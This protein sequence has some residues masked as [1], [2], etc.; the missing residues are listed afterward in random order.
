MSD[1]VSSRIGSFSDV[2]IGLY[3]D[4]PMW[5]DIS[6]RFAEKVSSFYKEE[7]IRDI[8]IPGDI[9]HN[10]SE[11][12]VK[13]IH[14]A[15]SFFDYFKDFNIII[16]AGN[17]D[18][19]FK[20]KAEINSIC[21]FDGWNNITIVDKTPYFIET[22]NGTTV[23]LI[24]WGIGSKDIPKT[25]VCFGH[26]EINTFYM[27][28]YRACEKGED[29][30]NL[31]NKSSFIISGHF[32]KKDH[33]KYD[34]GQ[35]LYLGSPYQQNF[36]DCDDERG[37]YIIDLDLKTFDFYSNEFSPRFVK[38]K[39][40]DLQKSTIN[41]TLKNNFISL[42]LEPSLKTEEVNKILNKIQSYLPNNVK[43]EYQETIKDN[44]DKEKTYDSIDILKNIYEYVETLDI[45]CKNE[46]VN[47]LTG[48]YNSLNK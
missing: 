25:D 48:V 11:I 5:H 33:R 3:Q 10:R 13:T 15:K 21:M 32:H 37:Y 38:I 1:I 9:F 31:L 36:G 35:I 6:L 8:I 14:T 27:N 45:E 43:I 17:H 46:V 29:S 24:P 18:S 23:S 42:T 26:F 22:S 30:K 19:F 44:N 16:S 41:N 7:G 39:S 20:E 47:Y 28:T 4:S 12:S 34:K 2:H 40:Q